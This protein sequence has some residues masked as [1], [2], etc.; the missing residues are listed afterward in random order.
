[1]LPLWSAPYYADEVFG[2]EALSR[3]ARDC[4]GEEDPGQIFYQGTLQEV[5]EIDDGRYLL[6]L[7]MPFVKSDEVRM[8]KRGDE[9]FITI[10]NFKRE[11]ILPMVLAKMRAGSGRLVNGKLEIEFIPADQVPNPVSV[12]ANGA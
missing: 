9:L 1:M 8:R 3:L 5:V 4:F 10:G 6:R 2:V 7:S 12:E 11:M